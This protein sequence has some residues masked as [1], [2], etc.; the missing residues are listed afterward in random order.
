MS[1]KGVRDSGFDNSDLPVRGAQSINSEEEDLINDFVEVSPE[2]VGASNHQSRAVLAPVNISMAS[3]NLL[4]R[5]SGYPVG[6]SFQSGSGQYTEIFEPMEWLREVK[7]IAA[8]A[9]WTDKVT[10]GN[11]Q[12]AM[13]PKSPVADWFELGVQV[14]ISMDSWAQFQIEFKKEYEGEV[15]VATTATILKNMKMRKTERAS[16]FLNRVKLEYGRLAGSMILPADLQSADQTVNDY[17]DRLLSVVGDHLCRAFFVA[18]IREELLSAV[19]RS[20][21]A[22]L[23]SIVKS[24]AIEEK[25]RTQN[26]AKIAVIEVEEEEEDLRSV[27]KT[28][29]QTV[30]AIKGGSGGNGSGENKSKKGKGK[31][32]WCFYC[33]K[34]GHLSSGC[35]LRR[36][37]R[38]V[39]DKWRP[40]VK[41]PPMSK[42]DYDALSREEKNRGKEYCPG[43]KFYQTASNATQSQAPKPQAA[44]QASF[45]RRS[46]EDEFAEYGG[47]KNS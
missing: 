2:S 24:C 14:G 42:Q 38:E 43:G 13:F 18:G 32:P 45:N 23:P 22:D 44:P 20:G 1:R 7:K 37:D 4:P 47:P 35:T 29:S 15:D 9:G 10:V 12:V 26:H 40:C 31:K 11:V 28:L 41:D 8:A 46:L 16:A 33:L 36:E 30:A 19:T 17:K 39:H 21:A 6:T 5:Y 25:I 3:V 27:V 34:Q